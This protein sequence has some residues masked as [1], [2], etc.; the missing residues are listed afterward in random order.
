LTIQKQ[1]LAKQGVIPSP[2]TRVSDLTQ[3]FMQSANI[4]ISKNPEL[5]ANN[6]IRF[7]VNATPEI[8]SQFKGIVFYGYGRKG[9]IEKNLPP[10]AGKAGDIIYDAQQAG[11]LIFDNE[12]NTYR[13]RSIN[14]RSYSE[15]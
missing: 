12:G 7:R 5:S 8:Q 15:R 13:L 10:G 2:E 3:V 9:D 1:I 6:I 4:A 11:F 14:I